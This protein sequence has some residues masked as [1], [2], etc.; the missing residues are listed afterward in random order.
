MLYLCDAERRED[1]GV[2]AICRVQEQRSGRAEGLGAG[3][4]YHQA[5]SD[6]WKRLR[7]H[8]R[9]ALSWVLRQRVWIPGHQSSK[10]SPQPRGVKARQPGQPGSSLD[11][12]AEEKAW[13]WLGGPA[14]PQVERRDLQRAHTHPWF[15]RIQSVAFGGF[16]TRQL[17]MPDVRQEGWHYPR[18]PYPA[19]RPLPRV[20]VR[21]G[22]R[23]YSLCIVS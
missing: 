16:Q 10:A 6:L 23:S 1:K 19:I 14:Q 17:D 22:Q 11:K 5:V 8:L 9:K 12:R 13:C 3:S 4:P 2:V 15:E 18:R 21:P 20:E 7:S